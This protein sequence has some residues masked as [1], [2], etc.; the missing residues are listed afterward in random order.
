MV[1]RVQLFN[2]PGELGTIGQVWF[3]ES[4]AAND[5]TH[6]ARRLREDLRDVLDARARK[7]RVELRYVANREEFFGVL[8]ELRNSVRSTKLN[9][10]LDIECH[11]D[12]VEGIQLADGTMVPWALLKLKLEGIN[13]ESR[14]NMILVLGC[15][16]GAFFGK[17]SRLHERAAFGAFIAPT[18]SIDVG[19]LAP[20][21][22]A[23][24]AEL[25]TSL[26]I[27]NA[28]GAMRSAAPEF[29]YMFF[30]AYG[31][32]RTIFA[33]SIVDHGM[34][35]GLHRRAEAM[36]ERLQAERGYTLSVDEVAQR[37]KNGV[38]EAFAQFRRTYFLIH[39]FPE[40]EDRFPLTYAQVEADA[41]KLG[42]SAAERT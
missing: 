22:R 36:A 31:L 28:I 41:Q 1:E 25:F 4:L 19:V 23:F 30:T 34:G 3:V 21:L 16:Y 6:T 33:E 13:V 10:I 32:F 14:C 7:L 42:I 15:C 5:F 35:Q 11:G 12:A 2:E 26:D 8:E 18:G 17:E 40:H 24:Y 29:G 37:L 9:P 20:G 39:E 38:P 27:T